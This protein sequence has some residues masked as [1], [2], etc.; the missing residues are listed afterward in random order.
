MFLFKFYINCVAIEIRV[1]LK[2]QSY[3][4]LID[5]R[6]EAKELLGFSSAAGPESFLDN[7]Q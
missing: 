6:Y 3:S 4:I 2:I 1:V 5:Y 7:L